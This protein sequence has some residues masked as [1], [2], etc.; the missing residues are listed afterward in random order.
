MTGDHSRDYHHSHLLL[1]NF[2]MTKYRLRMFPWTCSTTPN[3]G[4]QSYQWAQKWMS[5]AAF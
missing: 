4:N 2:I 1:F 5:D 3:K